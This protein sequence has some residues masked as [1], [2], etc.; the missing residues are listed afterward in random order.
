MLDMSLLL[1]SSLLSIPFLI[2]SVYLFLFPFML[3]T[4][5]RVSRILP[6]SAAFA[7]LLFWWWESRDKVW[8]G[9]DLGPRKKIFLGTTVKSNFVSQSPCARLLSPHPQHSPFRAIIA[10]VLEGSVFTLL[11]QALSSITSPCQA[12]PG[13]S[14]HFDLLWFKLSD[15]YPDYLS[16][17]WRS[18]RT[19]SQMQLLQLIFSHFSCFYFPLT[20]MVLFLSLSIQI[21]PYPLS[22]ATPRG[23]YCLSHTLQNQWDLYWAGS[24]TRQNR[25]EATEVSCGGDHNQNGWCKY[26]LGKG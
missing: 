16:C 26:S 3:R 19:S 25:V 4:E 5:P 10:T 14:T 13:P 24:S 12:F 9:E 23:F 22:L 1:S 11:L 7:S 8:F 15:S 21:N 17:H 2:L 18:S 6:L 20:T